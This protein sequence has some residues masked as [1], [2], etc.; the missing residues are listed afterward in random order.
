MPG[1]VE[2]TTS[3]S[4]SQEKTGLQGAILSANMLQIATAKGCALNATSLEPVGEPD[5]LL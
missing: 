1:R 5:Q 3:D 2:P 4:Y